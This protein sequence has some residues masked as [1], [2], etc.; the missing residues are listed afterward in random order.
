MGV[1]IFMIARQVHGPNI[2]CMPAIILAR[3]IAASRVLDP[4]ARPCLDLIDLEELLGSIAHLDID[5]IASGPG[6]DDQWHGA[7]R[8]E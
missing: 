4:G 3:R 6:I 5:T 7:G 1:R 2:P 8:H